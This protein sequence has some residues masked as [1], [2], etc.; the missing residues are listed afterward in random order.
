MRKLKLLAIVLGVLLLATSA[1]ADTATFGTTWRINDPADGGILR[2]VDSD[3]GAGFQEPYEVSTASDT[4]TA[5]ESGRVVVVYPT[6]NDASTTQ[7]Y[8]LPA[9][10][11][12]L[13]YTFT[14]GKHTTIKVDP[15]GTDQ[16]MYS[17]CAAGDSIS[18]PAATGDNVKLISDGTRWYVQFMRG[19]WTDSN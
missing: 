8:T 9:A 12:G 1:Y 7:T 14:E 13:N 18:S 3:S 16:I 6:A 2:P 11:D 19:T 15:N 5:A 4:L 17:T 10:A